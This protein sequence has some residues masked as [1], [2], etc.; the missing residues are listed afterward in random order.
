MHAKSLPRIKVLC[1]WLNSMD[2]NMCTLYSHK[3]LTPFRCALARFSLSETA[4]YAKL[5]LALWIGLAIPP[6]LGY[7]GAGVALASSAMLTLALGNSISASH[8]YFRKRV[9]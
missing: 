2:Q 7:P 4:K 5:T 9:V 1:T 6:Y 8:S 3:P